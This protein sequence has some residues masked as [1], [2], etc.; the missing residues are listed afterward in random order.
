MD[1]DTPVAEAFDD[2]L[3]EVAQVLGGLGDTDDFE[4]LR[5]R[6]VGILADPHTA[7]DL[8]TRAEQP[9]RKPGGGNLNLDLG[10]LADLAVNKITGP[11]HT[12]RWGVATT[13]LITRWLTHWLGPDARIVVKPFLDLNHPRQHRGGRR[14]RPTAPMIDFVRQRDPFCVFPGCT[15]PSRRCDLD[16]IEAYVPPDDGGPPGQTHPDNLVPQ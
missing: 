10:A 13:N 12:E 11:V 6:A 14:T 8:L 1:L 4:I 15:K 9:T 2:K 16:H 3:S 7:L 5:A